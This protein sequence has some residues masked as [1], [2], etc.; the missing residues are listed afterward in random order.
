[1]KSNQKKKR[2]ASKIIQNW[3]RNLKRKKNILD[4]NK[5]KSFEMIIKIQKWIR[6]FLLRKNVLQL[7]EYTLYYQGFC[8]IIQ[9]ILSF[10]VKKMVFRKILKKRNLKDVLISMIANEKY[11]IHRWLN[12]WKQKLIKEKNNR[13]LKRTFHIYEKKELKKEKIKRKIINLWIRKVIQKINIE[14]VATKMEIEI[15]QHIPKKT[16][17]DFTYLQ[18]ISKETVKED[19]IKL[20]KQL[21]QFFLKNLCNKINKNNKKFFF[22]KWKKLFEGLNSVTQLKENKIIRDAQITDF[23][24]VE[25]TKIYKNE[26][27]PIDYKNEY[28]INDEKKEKKDEGNDK[29][30]EIQNEAQDEF[31]RIQEEKQQNIIQKKN[32]KGEESN[33]SNGKTT[34]TKKDTKNKDLTSKKD[35]QIKKFIKD[36]T[37]E[38]MKIKDNN[39]LQDFE[40]FQN[41]NEC[42]KQD[43]NSN[44]EMEEIEYEEIKTV[45]RIIKIEREKIKNEKSKELTQNDDNKEIK[46]T[47][48]NLPEILDYILNMKNKKKIN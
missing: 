39:N 40:K 14:K 41:K 23:S 43:E 12:I 7:I 48:K 29:I 26:D 24:I 5:S 33:I 8:D 11:I 31:K 45:T 30:I 27:Q 16:Y 1:M 3:W 9:G 19:S 38:N 13:I 18:T 4:L 36:T 42:L 2:N 6:G 46:K 35:N 22:E 17:P 28:E 44:E 37:K 15:I 47:S 10:K 34:K 25:G 21:L 32:D 20:K